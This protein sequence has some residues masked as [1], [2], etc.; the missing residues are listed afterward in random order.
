MLKI[1]QVGLGPLGRKIVSDLHERGLGKVVA[2]ADTDPGVTG[3]AIRELVDAVPCGVRISASLQDALEGERAD[4]AIVTTSSNLQQCANTFR[5]L[6]QRGM[7]IVSTCEE[8]IWPRLRHAALADELHKVAL[9]HGGRLLGTG[10]NPGMMMDALP[11]FATAVCNDVRS[12]EIHRIQDA[13]TRR[14]PF[15]KKIGA[16]LN[17]EEFGAG[18][19]SGWLRHVG[20]GESLHLIADCMGWKVEAWDETIEPVLAT[21]AMRCGLGPIKKGDACGVR[22]TAWLKSGG[23]RTITAVFQAAI[24]QTDPEPQDR[25]II[26]GTPDLD[27]VYRGGV[28]GDIATSAI[29]LN[30]IRPLMDSAPGL[31]TMATIPMPR[32]A[33]A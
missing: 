30:C 8:L 6:L 3:K 11:V 23:I 22:Q 15:Q 14:I 29:T 19:A 26:R 5:G 16:G 31:H 2:A 18:I 9:D 27:L 10:V 4:V 32:W 13:A 1:L 33:R 21:R 25:I 24:G 28:H 7:P 17:A 20:L 12:I